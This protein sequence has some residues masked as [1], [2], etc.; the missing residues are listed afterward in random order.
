MFDPAR[1][2]HP[3]NVASYAYWDRLRG[4][5]TMPARADIDPMDIPKLLPSVLLYD[6]QAEP[7]DFRYRLIGTKIAGYLLADYT[8]KWMSELA[9]QRAPGRLWTAYT[10]VVT[11]LEPITSDAPYV[12]KYA[13]FKTVEDLIMPLSADGETVNMLFVTVDFL[14]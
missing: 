7:L 12:G 13:D 5:R 10:H 14:T 11:H 6:V 1:L 2:R 4:A 3:T 8:G 9:H